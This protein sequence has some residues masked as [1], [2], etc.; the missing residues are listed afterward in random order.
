MLSEADDGGT[1]AAGIT[2]DGSVLQKL[3]EDRLWSQSDLAA[4]T[5]AFALA[6]GDRQCG[7]RRETISK[8]ERGSRTPSPRT[9]R[10]LVGALRPTMAELHLLLVGEPPK[11]LADL[12]ADRGKEE[13]VKRRELLTSGLAAATSPPLHALERIAHALGKPTRVDDRLLDVLEQYTSRI[14]EARNGLPPS[15]VIQPAATHLRTLE[16]LHGNSMTEAHRRRLHVIASDAAVLV[17]WL[18]WLM[19]RHPNARDAMTLAHRLAREANDEIVQARVLG[20]TSWISSTIPSN[21]Q[22]GDT[23][24]ALAL[25]EHAAVLGRNASEADRSWLAERLAAEHAV[26]GDAD[27]CW[28]A[29]AV[30]RRLLKDGAIEPSDGGFFA[31]FLAR[32]DSRHIDGVVGLCRL[33]LDQPHEAE[34]MFTRLLDE[35]DPSDLRYLAVL[36]SDLAAAYTLQDEPERACTA[37][38]EAVSIAELGGLP[39][40]IER[41]RGVRAAMPAAWAG[42]AA[43][44]DL[45]ERLG[46][47]G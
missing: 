19:D 44:R 24:K 6:E 42:L 11:A 21:G 41:V 1:M 18:H 36:L 13:S 34:A 32:R 23:A 31:A 10:Y 15:A 39:L 27:A 40:N 14:G 26:V 28:Q 5:C 12:V 47:K 20:V 7:V 33:L 16:R 37:A 45:D 3:R 46:T 17:G 43:V 25:A 35:V 30:A 8:L 38:I 9:L 29:M 2:I 22:R 4:R